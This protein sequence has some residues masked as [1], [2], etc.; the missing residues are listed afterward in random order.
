MQPFGIVRQVDKN[1]RIVIPKEM[2]QQL[3]IENDVDGF[4]IFTE[5]NKLIL[6]KYQP[7]CIFCGSPDELFRMDGHL[8]CIDCVDRLWA[9]K[10]SL[11]G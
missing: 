7:N 10:N 9:M 2:R 6:R 8:V 1:G 3:G 5:G 11:N 4:E